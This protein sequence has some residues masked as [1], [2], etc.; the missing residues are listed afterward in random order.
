VGLERLLILQVARITNCP[1]R[2]RL[3]S[4]SV[5]RFPSSFRLVS[6]NPLSNV[7]AS[8]F[9]GGLTSI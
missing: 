6:R 4:T 2:E 1:D 7:A 8:L 5:R 3:S 9:A